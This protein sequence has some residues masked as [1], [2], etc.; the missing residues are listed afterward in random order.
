MKQRFHRGA[1]Q[2]V[3]SLIMAAIFLAPV[4]IIAQT[5]STP[6]PTLIVYHKNKYSPDDDVKLGR[7]AATQAERQLRILPDKEVTDYLESVGQRLVAAI[8]PEFQHREFRYYFR[9]VEDR[10]INA[11]A[12]PG[13]PMYVNTGTILAAHNEGELAGVMAHELSHVALRHGTAQAT[14]AQKYNILALMAGITGTIFAG[15]EAGQAAEAP[16]QLYFMKYSREYETE[17][18]LLGARIM[19][20]AGYDPHDLANMFKTIQAQTGSNGG[21]WF[22]DHPSSK[23]RYEKINDEA[24]RL[25]IAANPIKVTPEFRAAQERLSGYSSYANGQGGRN[26]SGGNNSPSNAPTGRVEPPSSQYRSY[27]ELGVVRI[28]VPDNWQEQHDQSSVWFGPESGYGSANGQSVFTHGLNIGTTKTNSTN[29]QQATDEF[30]SSLERR[31]SNIRSRSGYQRTNVSGR[32]ALSISLSNIN[33]ATGRTEVIDVVTTQLRNGSL[34][35]L[36]TVVPESDYNNYQSTF[37]SIMRS[38][39]LTD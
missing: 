31:G 15:P 18:D 8:P 30:I 21:G 24:G 38:V 19:S 25:Q 16:F 7:Q 23:D 28:D 10:Q 5:Q 34:L 11:F 13:G 2:L 32:N 26:R 14:K 12:L 22:S 20:R 39:Q 1:K 4:S 17:A 27:S 29:L 33:E 9:V 6:T 37:Q 3:G 35:Y 36:I